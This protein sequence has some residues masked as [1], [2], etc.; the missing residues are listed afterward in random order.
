MIIFNDTNYIRVRETNHE[1]L[2]ELVVR[3]KGPHKSL[4]QFAIE[5]GSSPATIHRIVEMKNAMKCNDELIFK[6]AEHAEPNSGV[7]LDLLLNAQGLAAVDAVTKNNRCYMKMQQESMMKY[8][9]EN[10]KKSGYSASLTYE[11][12]TQINY[13]FD[14]VIF[15][16]A[17]GKDGG[18]WAFDCVAPTQIGIENDPGFLARKLEKVMSMFYT[19][20]INVDKVSIVVPTR[21]MLEQIVNRYNDCIIPDEISIILLEG[22]EIKEEYIMPMYM[23]NPKSIFEAVNERNNDDY[24][25]DK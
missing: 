5:L 17:V 9:M 13:A 7:T 12:N 10:I 2:S 25:L 15:S 3:A 4:R 20:K 19:N 8:V 11:L 21:N 18:L 16:D 6:I 23:R 14:K 1:K 24:S 22:K